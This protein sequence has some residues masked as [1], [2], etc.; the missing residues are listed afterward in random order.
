MYCL[1]RI[2]AILAFM[3]MAT[4]GFAMLEPFAGE[5]ASAL[6]PTQALDIMDAYEYG[7]ALEVLR[8]WKNMKD[9]THLVDVDRLPSGMDLLIEQ[10]RKHLIVSK[11]FSNE[12]AFQFEKGIEAGLKW[13]KKLYST[14]GRYRYRWTERQYYL[15]RGVD[16]YV[17]L[18]CADRYK[19][20]R[21]YQSMTR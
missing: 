15:D 21:I 13:V 11:A 6:T 19:R 18:Q 2:T 4:F 14:D 1:K 3:S 20:S 17:V 8:A 10:S 7:F 5:E 12:V 9:W 16:P